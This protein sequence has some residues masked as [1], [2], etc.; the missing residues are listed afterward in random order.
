MNK[1]DNKY[2]NNNNNNNNRFTTEDSDTWNITHN[3]ESTAV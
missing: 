2:N 3:T 1:G